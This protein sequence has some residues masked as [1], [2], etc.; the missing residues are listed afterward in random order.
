MTV[1]V[2][3]SEVPAVDKYTK[4]DVIKRVQYL[5]DETLV[6]CH[7]K[8]RYTVFPIQYQIIS[9]LSRNSQSELDL[10][11]I[12]MLLLKVRNI[13]IIIVEELYHL[14]LQHVMHRQ[15]IHTWDSSPQQASLALHFP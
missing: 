14:R 7:W 12:F 5:T 3:D 9:V 4:V 15:S 8:H 6:L 1:C 13:D 11:V 2:R 10:P